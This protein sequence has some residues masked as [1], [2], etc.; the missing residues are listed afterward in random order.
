M[1]G[2]Q[3]KAPGSRGGPSAGPR[4][5]VSLG[6]GT[7]EPKEN[8]ADFLIWGLPLTQGTSTVPYKKEH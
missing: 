4:N 5:S 6:L 1:R 8:A 2:W 3:F 7:G